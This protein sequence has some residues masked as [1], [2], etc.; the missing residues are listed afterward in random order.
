M[1]E[2]V[3]LL[4]GPITDLVGKFVRDKDE[5]ARLAHDIATL[6]ETQAHEQVL[7]QIDVNKEQAKHGSIFV[8]GARPA[9]MW[10]CGFSLA[11]NYVLYPIVLWAVWLFPEYQSVIET[12]PK[13]DDGQMITVLLGLLGLGGMRSFEKRH[14]V[15]RSNL[16]QP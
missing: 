5:A 14:G 7:A 12:A 6:V 2:W 9:I 10:V 8:A 4:V 3:R 1:I 13:L 11:W 15:A 16:A